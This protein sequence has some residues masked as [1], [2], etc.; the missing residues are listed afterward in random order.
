MRPMRYALEAASVCSHRN[1]VR[2][3]HSMPEYGSSF[4]EVRCPLSRQMATDEMGNAD[5]GGIVSC[6]QHGRVVSQ[7]TREDDTVAG[8]SVE[9]ASD[10]INALRVGGLAVYPLGVLAVIAVVIVVDKMFLFFVC[11]RLPPDL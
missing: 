4:E 5:A 1:S 7:G 8:V 9:Q 2:A 10:V 6:C 3:V 11:T